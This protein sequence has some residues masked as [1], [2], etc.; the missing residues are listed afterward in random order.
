MA[1]KAADGDYDRGPNQGGSL[2]EPMFGRTPAIPNHPA[3]GQPGAQQ[4]QDHVQARAPPPHYMAPP[5][6][7]PSRSSRDSHGPQ[8]GQEM[9]HS[10]SRRDSRWQPRVQVCYCRFSHRCEPEWKY[11]LSQIPSN[12]KLCTPSGRL[13]A[14]SSSLIGTSLNSDGR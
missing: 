12:A 10:D 3:R 5:P 4:R 1:C 8:S 11:I 7:P 14:F 9:A 13:P 2:W 6:K